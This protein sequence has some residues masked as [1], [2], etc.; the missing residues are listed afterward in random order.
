MRTA[1]S[2]SPAGRA[3][4]A[5][6]TLP[7]G[8][9]ILS[10]TR[11][12]GRVT[13]L[14]APG[15]ARLDGRQLGTRLLRRFGEV[16]DGSPPLDFLSA[17]PAGGAPRRV[18][19][20]RAGAGRLAVVVD[21]AEDPAERQRLLAEREEARQRLEFVVGATGTGFD[22]IDADLTMQYIDPARM[23]RF[24]DFRGRKCYE[25]FRGRAE[26]CPGCA[27][28]GALAAHTVVVA[29][30]TD[31]AEQTRPTQVTAIPFRSESGSWMV[32][33]VSIDI[34][35][36]KKAEA[37]RLALERRVL[38]AQKMEG[39]GVLA[40]GVA[41]NFNNL[42]SVMLGYAQLLR[43]M[44][45]ADP[46][47]HAA[48]EEILRAGFRARD[49]VRQLLAVG[50]RQAID[51]APLDLN[52]LIADSLGILR[53]AVRE[54][55]ELEVDLSP[56][57]CPVMANPGRVEQVLLNLVLNAQDATSGPGR[58][59]FATSEVDLAAAGEAARG[60]LP[61]GRYVRLVVSDTGSGMDKAT[62]ARI[63]EPFFTT[64]EEGKGTGLGLSTVYGIVR[65]FGGT[66]EVESE[67]GR[68]ARF[69]IL[70]PWADSPAPSV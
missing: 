34:S 58:I 57:P 62:M 55:I 43:E 13:G 15:G 6:D 31:P 25:Y 61:P 7:L 8:C 27:V 53:H 65:H 45:P 46:D 59:L 10:V 28:T 26:P 22:I 56:S 32:A 49:L 4:A 12:G 24:G 51:L 42:L 3:P 39:L 37:E 48:L 52:R 2:P 18:R 63:F 70:L 20:F 17:S 23:K 21:P 50:R 19:V 64:K 9:T 69:T 60:E 5:L 16:A 44:K 54:D 67:P 14:R 11:E 68:G 41:H 40:G 1:R 66:I 30:L 36:R 33:E 38:S 47:Y 35:E 29:D